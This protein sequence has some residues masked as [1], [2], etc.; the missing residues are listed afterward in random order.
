MSISLQRLLPLFERELSLGH[1]TVLGTVVRTAGPTYTKAGAQMLIALDGEYAGLLSG[2]CLEG[3]LRDRAGRVFESGC[4]EIVQYDMRGPDDLLFGLGSGC[5][6]A[7]T[8][9]LQRVDAAGDWQPL[10]RLAAAWR[11]RRPERALLIA[12]AGQGQASSCVAGAGIFLNDGSRFGAA[13]GACLEQL[14]AVA[15][16]LEVGEGSR[17]LATPWPGGELLLLEQPAPPRLLLLGAGPDSQPVAHLSTF[18]G[19]SVTVVDHRSH[20]ARPDRFPDADAVSDGGAA[21]VEHL[22][23]AATQPFNAAIVMSHHLNSDRAYL[24]VLAD[25]SIGYVGLLGP[26]ARRDRLLSELDEPLAERLAPRLH[27]PVGLD[28]GASTPEGI[29]LSIVAEIQAVLAGNAPMT[30]LSLRASSPRT[31]EVLT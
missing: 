5:E 19:W 23:R 29:A 21:A 31:E 3:D 9:L 17:P 2:G 4:A 7:M 8:I 25:S 27:A 28:L 30:P 18:M 20:Y 10:R 14:R 16:R 12:Q 13:D 15:Q 26:A 6:G 24:R 11:A 1:P 22:L